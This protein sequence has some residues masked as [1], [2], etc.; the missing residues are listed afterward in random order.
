MG[1]IAGSIEESILYELLVFSEWSHEH[2]V[3]VGLNYLKPFLGGFAKLIILL[4]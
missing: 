2:D 1:D 3:H 4:E